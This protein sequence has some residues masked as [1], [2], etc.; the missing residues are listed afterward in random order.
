MKIFAKRKKTPVKSSGAKTSPIDELSNSSRSTFA[1]DPVVEDLLKNKDPS[2]WNSKE[3]RLIKR[4]QD[5]KAKE[6]ELEEG[7]VVTGVA[8]EKE[9]TTEVKDDHQEEKNGSETG[10]DSE[11]SN[12]GSDS[13]S[14]DDNDASEKN[15]AANVDESYEMKD[16]NNE[17][18]PGNEEHTLDLES[19]L[20]PSS[21]EALNSKQR[22]KLTRMLASGGTAAVAQVVQEAS[23]IARGDVAS[24]KP[25]TE[26][27]DTKIDKNNANADT[28][29][30]HTEGASDRE[31][32]EEM[33]KTL[34]SKQRRKLSR[35]LEREGDSCLTEVRAEAE[36]LLNDTANSSEADKAGSSDNNNGPTASG[37]K[38]KR[39]RGPA[40]LSGLTPEERLRREEQ[41]KIQKEAAEARDKGED[42]TPGHKHPLNSERRRANKRKPKW[43]PKSNNM[44]GAIP[45]KVDHNASGFRHRKVTKAEAAV[46]G[47]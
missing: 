24:S 30:K 9:T 3:K 15:D 28:T 10:S 39:R 25:T 37:N 31:Q 46:Q 16:E 12:S 19:V 44:G 5:R 18:L 47:L 29:A 43:T 1:S 27:T 35:R 20:D 34:N 33:L 8:K 4:Y 22:R 11:S 36:K 21:L 45:E 14:D 13:G 6:G 2:E 38:R 32:V 7:A 41:R 40:D 26:S 23:V 42:K 17:E